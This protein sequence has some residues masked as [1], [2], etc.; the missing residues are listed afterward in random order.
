[1]LNQASAAAVAAPDIFIE[2]RAEERYSDIVER[3][4]ITFRGRDY[5]VAVVNISARG[6]QIESD[7]K[8]RMGESLIIQF[9]N[10][11]RM[12]GFVRWVRED[13]LGIRFGHEIILAS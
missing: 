6:T 4:T 9:E 5:P 3:A 10:C 7:I 13:K 11:S 1:M 8:P 12:H 2:H